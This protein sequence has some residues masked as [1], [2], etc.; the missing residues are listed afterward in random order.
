MTDLAIHRARGHAECVV[1][2]RV[3]LW[4]QALSDLMGDA[5]KAETDVDE[6][7]ELAIEEGV[8]PIARVR[9]VGGR[10]GR[11]TAHATLSVRLAGN[12]AGAHNTVTEV[13][14]AHACD[15]VLIPNP[16]VASA[17]SEATEVEAGVALVGVALGCC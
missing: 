8:G 12:A 14:A 2:A 10:V 9:A 5:A 3:D 11:G 7:A 16:A 13:I 4:L 6:V 17:R 15:P 1:A